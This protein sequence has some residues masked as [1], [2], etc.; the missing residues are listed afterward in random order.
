MNEKKPI[1]DNAENRFGNQMRLWGIVPF[2]H[3]DHES[4]IAVEHKV[5]IPQ[6]DNIDTIVG[7]S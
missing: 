3:P 6:F 2:L 5:S 7:R 1:C 4:V